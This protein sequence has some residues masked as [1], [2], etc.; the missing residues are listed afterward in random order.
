MAA[1]AKDVWELCESPPD[2]CDD[3]ADLY[4]WSTNY[5][6]GDGPFAL[7]LDMIGWS[8][9]E[10]GMPAYGPTVRRLE[11]SRLESWDSRLGYLELDKLADALKQ[12]ADRPHDVRA[13]VDELMLAEGRD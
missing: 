13:F 9:E 5:D 3:V 8:D 11:G 10:L 7:F 2:G 1:A 6:A 4:H 12:Y